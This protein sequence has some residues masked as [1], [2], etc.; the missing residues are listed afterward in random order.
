M[1]NEKIKFG[2]IS[3]CKS[4]YAKLVVA[5]VGVQTLGDQLNGEGL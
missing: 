1:I 3:N 2:N 4:V 5:L